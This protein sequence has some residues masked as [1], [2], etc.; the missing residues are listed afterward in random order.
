VLTCI[1]DKS[2]EADPPLYSCQYSKQLV[3]SQTNQRD[4]LHIEQCVASRGLLTAEKKLLE[5][6]LLELKRNVWKIADALFRI[7]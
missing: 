7:S 1:G 4:L 2:T 5:K 6:K 3:A